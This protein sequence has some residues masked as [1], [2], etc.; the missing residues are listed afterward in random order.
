MNLM[1]T[2]IVQLLE[3]EKKNNYFVIKKN[4]SY[5]C[6]S[7]KIFHFLDISN[8]LAPG[9]SYSKFLKAFQVPESKFYFPYEWFDDKTKLDWT[10]LPPPDAFYSSLKVQNTLGETESDIVKNYAFVQKVWKEEN[11]RTFQ[12]FLMHYN[13]LD[14]GPFVKAVEKMHVFYR[15]NGI[16]YLKETISVPGIARKMMFQQSKDAL[17]LLCGKKDQDLY[18]T[19]K[20]YHWWSFHYILST[21]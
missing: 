10:H 3:L 1:K 2:E 15:D 21:S 14:V 13:N 18:K 20:K 9:C 6:L 8:F 11:M 4:N 7:D 16:D 5:M 17:F 19:V 12:D